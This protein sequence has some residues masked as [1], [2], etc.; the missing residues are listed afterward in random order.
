MTMFPRLCVAVAANFFVVAAAGAAQPGAAPI[1]NG[2]VAINGCWRGEGNAVGKVFVALD[3]KPILQGAMFRVDVESSAIADPKDRYSAHLIFGSADQRA[4]RR[5]DDIVGFWADS[6]GGA[7]TA[8]GRGKSHADGFDMTYP[9][10]D[11]TFV[12][13]WRLSVDRLTWTIFARDRG[14]AERPFADYAMNRVLCT[15]ASP[16]PDT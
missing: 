15:S 9:Y 8:L 10:P 16:Q 6:F 3:A 2:V 11:A 7:Y 12:N 4:D 13:R 1:P 14:G 5:G